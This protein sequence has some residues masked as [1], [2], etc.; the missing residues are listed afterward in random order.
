MGKYRWPT[1]TVRMAANSIPEESRIVTD[2]RSVQCSWCGRDLTDED[3]TSLTCSGCGEHLIGMP[4]AKCPRCGD[5]ISKFGAKYC[6][7]CGSEINI[8]VV[9]WSG[10]QVEQDVTDTASGGFTAIPRPI[11]N[12]ETCSFCGWPNR[13]SHIAGAGT[14]ELCL[15]TFVGLAP[16]TGPAGWSGPV[17]IK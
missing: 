6:T 9:S 13:A 14:C 5:H 3:L 16:G 11:E 8:P 12:R 17:N 15:R 10:S 1:S 7:K 2:S 4:S